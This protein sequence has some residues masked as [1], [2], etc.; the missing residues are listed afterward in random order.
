MGIVAD[1]DL[2]LQG[3]ERSLSTAVADLGRFCVTG[4]DIFLEIRATHVTQGA[5]TAQLKLLRGIT[6]AADPGFLTMV[7][8]LAVVVVATLSA[9]PEVFHMSPDFLGYGAFVLFKCAGN[10]GKG[11]LGIKHLL[12]TLTILQCQMFVFHLGPSF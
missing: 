1:V 11:F 12:D 9:N 5:A 6:G 10:F 8:I 2:F 7:A 4:T 3:T